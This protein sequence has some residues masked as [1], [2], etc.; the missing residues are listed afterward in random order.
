MTSTR[1]PGK[2]LIPIVNQ[3]L[4]KYHTDRLL[5]SGLPVFLA[6]TNKNTDDVI[7][8]FAKK[9]DIKIYR[10]DEKNVL[11]RYYHTALQY[12]LEII[13]RVTSDCPL[14]DGSYIGKAVNQ[15]QRNHTDNIYASNV[16]NRTFPRGFDF[17]IFS[18]KSLQEAF[19]HATTAFETEHVTP[20]IREHNQ[21]QNILFK[22]DYSHFRIT[23]D[24]AADFELIRILI[25]DY[26]AHTLNHEDIISLLKEHPELVKINA[27]VEQKNLMGESE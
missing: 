25:Q 22:E 4:L 19:L 20:Y 9:E 17:E 5:E 21:Q 7:E 3:P 24:T 23:V 8:T 26:Q 18:F 27:H 11:A 16:V 13:V 6:T 10:G 2:V 15:F 1:L 12:E 14:I